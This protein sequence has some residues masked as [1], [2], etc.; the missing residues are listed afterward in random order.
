MSTPWETNNTGTITRTQ[1]GGSQIAPSYVDP[2]ST[3]VGGLGGLGGTD[4]SR[5]RAMEAAQ[6]DPN[7]PR[8]QPGVYAPGAAAAGAG[9]D[10]MSATI[11]QLLQ[12]LQSQ[13]QG[14]QENMSGMVNNWMAAA[15]GW[16]QNTGDPN[17]A[18]K[19][20][21]DA[22]SPVYRPNGPETGQQ[23][24]NGVKNWGGPF[25]STF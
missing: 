14:F 10:D 12:G 18:Y 5:L 8:P 2:H 15:P 19:S 17:A 11:Q 23:A 3:V 24:T 16:G 25:R 20:N 4:L 7:N 1:G 13:Q 22:G 21:S 9:G 6:N